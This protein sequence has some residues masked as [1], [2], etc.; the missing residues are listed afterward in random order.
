MGEVAAEGSTEPR[1][2]MVVAFTYIVPSLAGALGPDAEVVLHEL[3]HPEDSVI[4]IGGDVTG[5][6][7]GSPLTDLVLRHIRQGNLEE[8]LISY[9]SLSPGGRLLRSSTTFIRDEGGDIVGCL[10]I[11]F[12][13]TRF[14][15]V[16]QALECWCETQIVGEDAPESFSED[17]ERLLHSKTA[18]VIEQGGVP[19]QMMKRKDRLAVVKRLDEQGVFLIRGAVARVAKALAVSRYTIY[20]YLD[21]IRSERPL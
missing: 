2:P 21:E 9:A 17:V 7:V 12:D 19:V 3:S 10:C 11:N 5:R 15:A 4:A 6:T 20:N 18:D 13:L 1:S 16:K 14:T 8:D